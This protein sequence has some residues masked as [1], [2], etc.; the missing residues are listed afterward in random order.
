MEGIK[1][2]GNTFCKAKTAKTKIK[3]KKK[4]KEI[5]LRWQ[6]SFLFFS[7]CF[8]VILLLEKQFHWQHTIQCVCDFV[9]KKIKFDNC[10][11]LQHHRFHVSNNKEQSLGNLV[12]RE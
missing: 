8:L 6:E 4:K 9:Q 10:T 3:I 12:S 2:A 5:L 11:R 1:N 7:R